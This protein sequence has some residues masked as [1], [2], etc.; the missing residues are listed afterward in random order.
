MKTAFVILLW[1]STALAQSRIPFA[2]ATGDGTI[3][4]QPDQAKIVFSVVTQAANAQDASAQNANLVTNVLNQLKGLLGMNADIRTIGYSLSP[5]YSYPPNQ[6]PVLQ[7]YTAANSIQVT[8]SDLTVVGKA[9]DTGIAAGANQVSSL[10][11][12]LKDDSAA[13]AQALKLATIAAK[14]NADAMASGAGLRTG[15]VQ[16]I[17][18][19]VNTT[20]VDVRLGAAPTTATTPIQ[21]GTV[22]VKATVTLDISLQ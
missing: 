5:N 4:V 14:A 1:A 13:R 17:Q 7:G 12:G 9:I 11:F 22:E 19:G 15:A 20:P 2:R 6:A 18:E 21:S 3:A 8:T 10:Q 16:V